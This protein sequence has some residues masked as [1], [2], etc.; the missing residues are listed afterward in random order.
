MGKRALCNTAYGVLGL[1]N[2]LIASE[3]NIT[4]ESLQK[5]QKQFASRRK[6]SP[7]LGPGSCLY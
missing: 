1:S 2:Q 7:P 4:V 6:E 5:N 3:I